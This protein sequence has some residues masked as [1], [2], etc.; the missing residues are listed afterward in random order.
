MIKNSR[1]RGVHIITDDTTS[2]QNANAVC[3]Q[4]YTGTKQQYKSTITFAIKSQV[5]KALY[6]TVW[7]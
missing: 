1:E 4:V 2:D 7:Y 3:A 5:N 6:K